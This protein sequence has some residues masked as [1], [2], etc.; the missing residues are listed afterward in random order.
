MK[1]LDTGNKIKLE[2]L[3]STIFEHFR[4]CHENHILTNRWK[5]QEKSNFC[6]Q[7]KNDKNRSSG[8]NNYKIWS[9]TG[10]TSSES[11]HVNT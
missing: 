5:K 10:F 4:R 1:T 7:N 11:W 2:P 6:W 8:V 9:S 3:L